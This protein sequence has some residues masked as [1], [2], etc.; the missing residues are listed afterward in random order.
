MLYN[1]L[2]KGANSVSRSYIQSNR[3]KHVSKIERFYT[4]ELNQTERRS[5]TTRM[6]LLRRYWTIEDDCRNYGLVHVID[7]LYDNIHC[8]D[9]VNGKNQRD[10][11]LLRTYW[12]FHMA[13]P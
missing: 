10:E 7:V 2:L 12:G 8:L 6:L 9:K 11:D 3:N 5:T 13:I 4:R 1:L